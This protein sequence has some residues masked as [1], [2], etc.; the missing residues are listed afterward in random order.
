MRVWHGCGRG[1]LTQ[2]MLLEHPQPVLWSILIFPMCADDCSW[3]EIDLLLTT[4]LSISLVNILPLITQS[5]SL[6]NK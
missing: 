5:K 2:F 6:Y 3:P 4:L 1:A